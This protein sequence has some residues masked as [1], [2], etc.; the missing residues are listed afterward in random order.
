VLAK[1]LAEYYN[2]D[3]DVERAV[4]RS[5]KR[6]QRFRGDKDYVD[7]YDLV[8][9]LASWLRGE[10]PVADAIA[11]LQAALPEPGPDAPILANVKGSRH[12]GAHGLSI[13]FPSLGCSQYYENIELANLGWRDLVRTV[14]A[15]QD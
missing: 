13:Y 10:G 2:D 12:R 7:L 4:D 1:A 11:S 9:Q 5:L 14:N 6:V 3:F 8:E 15:V